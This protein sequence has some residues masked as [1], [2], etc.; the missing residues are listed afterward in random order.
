MYDSKSRDENLLVVAAVEGYSLKHGI[1]AKET[2]SLFAQKD[3]MK[4]IRSN[5]GTLHTQS[6]SESVAFVEDVLARQDV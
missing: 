6:L 4:I 3:L 2:I 1:S 5:Y